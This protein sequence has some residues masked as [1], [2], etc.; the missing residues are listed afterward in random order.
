[1]GVPKTK[2]EKH[3]FF[4][5]LEIRNTSTLPHWPHGFREKQ[6]EQESTVLAKNGKTY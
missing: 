3:I 1:M 2:R 4:A 5:I 6:M